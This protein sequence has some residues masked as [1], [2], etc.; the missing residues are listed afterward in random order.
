[1]KIEIF[2]AGCQKCSNLERYVR[3]AVKELD[4]QAEIVKVNDI[5]KMVERGIMLT[6]ALFVDGNK[7]SQGK[8]PSLAEIKNIL[9][10]VLK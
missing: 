7:K 2:G 6:P 3:D 4:C 5:N 9:K 1:M 10:E 8:V